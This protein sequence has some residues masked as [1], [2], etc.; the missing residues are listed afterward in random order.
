MD[1]KE[2]TT[3]GLFVQKTMRLSL[4]SFPTNTAAECCCQSK[5]N[6]T[7]FEVLRRVFNPLARRNILPSCAVYDDIFLEDNCQ[8]LFQESIAKCETPGGAVSFLPTKEEQNECQMLEMIRNSAEN[9]YFLPLNASQ[10]LLEHG[11]IS[12]NSSGFDG[13]N[14][15]KYSDDVVASSSSFDEPYEDEDSIDDSEE[16]YNYWIPEKISNLIPTRLRWWEDDYDNF[17]AMPKNRKKGSTWYDWNHP[18]KNSHPH[19]LGVALLFSVVAL[20]TVRSWT[21]HRDTNTAWDQPAS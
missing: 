8:Y 9:E 14:E 15:V 19:A 11:S 1:R 20:I 13:G 6:R 4:E 7:L 10:S 16:G 3:R 17:S 5:E 21:R 2:I 18:H 12:S